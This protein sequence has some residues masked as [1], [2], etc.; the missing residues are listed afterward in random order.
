MTTDPSRDDFTASM[1]LTDQERRK[2]CVY[3]KHMVDMEQQALESKELLLSKFAEPLRDE[4]TKR[5]K[6]LIAAYS[7]VAGDLQKWDEAETITSKDVSSADILN[8]EGTKK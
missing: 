4:M 3:C 8:D 6:T 5:D 2:F 1:E 7:I